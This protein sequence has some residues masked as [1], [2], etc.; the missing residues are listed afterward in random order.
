MGAIVSYPQFNSPSTST[1]RFSGANVHCVTDGCDHIGPQTNTIDTATLSWPSAVKRT[2]GP[3]PTQTPGLRY[4]TDE[5]I[6]ALK[7]EV[8]RVSAYKYMSPEEFI[9]DFIPN[10]QNRGKVMADDSYEG[11]VR[12]G[13][14]SKYFD[15]TLITAD[16]NAPLA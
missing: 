1:D 2:A 15:R 14:D 7:A 16:V 13:F 12:E 8:D 10:V 3:A 9:P 4:Y 6:A 5:E 11:M